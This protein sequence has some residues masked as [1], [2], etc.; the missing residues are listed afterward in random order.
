LPNSLNCV[1]CGIIPSCTTAA[2]GRRPLLTRRS[3]LVVL[4]SLAP[5]L[6]DRV[7]TRLDRLSQQAQL[8]PQPLPSPP[9]RPL[10]IPPNCSGWGALSARLRCAC[11]AAPAIA[12]C[13][14]PR[15][16]PGLGLLRRANLAA[17]YLWGAYLTIAH[18]LAGIRY[19][20]LSRPLQG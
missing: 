11:A 20:A 18:R 17:F 3:A 6:L 4:S 13:W 8:Q 12:A 1:D 9:Q 10:S 7:T 5:Y 14:G 19:I 15:V 16:P 2:T